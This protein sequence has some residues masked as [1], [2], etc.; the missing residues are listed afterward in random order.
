MNTITLKL[1]TLAL[2]ISLALGFASQNVS[3]A[4]RR[5]RSQ[6]PLKITP[7]E[8]KPFLNAT[9]KRVRTSLSWSKT[10]L[11][12]SKRV[13]ANASQHVRQNMVNTVAG[14]SFLS[15]GAVGLLSFDGGVSLQHAVTSPS[16]IVPTLL[17]SAGVGRI[18]TK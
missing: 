15:I 5:G 14:L 10:K 6:Q 3:A 13:V 1:S 9:F 16:N 18:L 12:S 8:E 17:I 4:D 11:Q 2:T 7:N